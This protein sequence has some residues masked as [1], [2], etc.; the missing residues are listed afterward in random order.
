M[1]I[2]LVRSNQLF[3]ISIF[4]NY[5]RP[6]DKSYAIEETVTDI[7]EFSISVLEACLEV[8]LKFFEI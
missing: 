7:T 4:I 6:A 5:L 2:F 8:D 3:S 1:A